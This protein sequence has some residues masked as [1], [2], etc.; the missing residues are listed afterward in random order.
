MEYK[1]ILEIINNRLGE[2]NTII[3]NAELYKKENESRHEDNI[4][5]G[6][7]LRLRNEEVFLDWL[8]KRV[9]R[10]ETSTKKQ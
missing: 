7:L 2:V 8:K 9:T 1:T 3:R 4:V 5:D 6:E 10:T